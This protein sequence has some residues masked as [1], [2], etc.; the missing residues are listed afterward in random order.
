[1]YGLKRKPTVG[2]N[3]MFE[4]D[5]FKY[6]F[7]GGYPSP[8]ARLSAPLTPNFIKCLTEPIKLTSANF[9]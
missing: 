3:E 2:I 7:K 8:L 9:R 4:K 5:V 1:M 6:D